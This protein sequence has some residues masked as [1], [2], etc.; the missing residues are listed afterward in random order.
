MSDVKIIPSEAKILEYARAQT[1]EVLSDSDVFKAMPLDDQKNIYLSMVNDQ[2]A[3]KRKEYGIS[4]SMAT[5]SGKEM[6][7]KGYDPGFQGDTQSFKE[8]V[9]SVD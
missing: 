6:G 4:T 7:Y 2:V 3:K 5:D 9:D 1:R 8:L